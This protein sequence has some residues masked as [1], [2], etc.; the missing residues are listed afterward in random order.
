MPLLPLGPF[1]PLQTIL[2]RD[3]V[4]SDSPLQIVMAVWHTVFKFEARQTAHIYSAAGCHA[5]L[6][7]SHLKKCVIRPFLSAEGCH[8]WLDGQHCPLRTYHGIFSRAEK[9][10][11]DTNGRLF[12]MNKKGLTAHR[13]FWSLWQ[14]FSI[15]HIFNV[16]LSELHQVN[17]VRYYI[18]MVL[19]ICL[20]IFSFWTFAVHLL[21]SVKKIGCSFSTQGFFCP[22]T[23][24][25]FYV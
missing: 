22:F 19:Y 7:S 24:V 18:L 10:S 16:S 9:P 8:T 4:G 20:A 14:E 15:S 23:K 2:L 6:A 13:A 5:G 3:L 11:E 17:T 12:L 21:L 25:R 1:C